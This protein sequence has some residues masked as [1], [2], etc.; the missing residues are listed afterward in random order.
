M[1]KIRK[2]YKIEYAHQLTSAHSKVCTETIHGHSATIELFFTDDCLDEDGMVIDFGKVDSIVN[3]YIYKWDHALIMS[4]Y[5]DPHYLEILELNNVKLRV[6][7]YNPTA[8]NMAKHMYIHICDLLAK[9]EVPNISSIRFHETDSGWAE[10][11]RDV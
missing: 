11:G 2:Q 7:P 5:A 8:E 4:S 6:I 1:Y 10:Y 3:D 9:H